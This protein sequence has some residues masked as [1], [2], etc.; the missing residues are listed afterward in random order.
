MS[1]TNLPSTPDPIGGDASM[2]IEGTGHHGGLQA[3]FD[4]PSASDVRAAD[5]DTSRG[6]SSSAKKSGGVKASKKKAAS[7]TDGSESDKGAAA[8]H[9]RPRRPK[10]PRKGGGSKSHRHGGKGGRRAGHGHGARGSGGG[11]G[12]ASKGRRDNRGPSSNG[13]ARE[14]SRNLPLVPAGEEGIIYVVGGFAPLAG[15]GYI[16]MYDRKRSVRYSYNYFTE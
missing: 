14:E 9:R 3:P 8:K 11:P 10:G 5:E 1:E 15:E 13:V 6:R 2:E 12:R 16:E 4:E 7:D